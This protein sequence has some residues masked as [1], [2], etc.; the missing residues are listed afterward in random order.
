MNLLFMGGLSGV[1]DDVRS[2]WIGPIF[3]IILMSMALFFAF[4]R[5]FREMVIF[6]AIAAV[7]GVLIYGGGVLFGQGGSA[8]S[9][10][11]AAQNVAE[12]IG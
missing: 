1:V 9:I 12:K 3:L 5:Q 6:I 10:T 7:A 4:K 8:G 2:N 11:N